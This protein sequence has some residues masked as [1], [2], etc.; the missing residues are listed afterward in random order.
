LSDG[1]AT[2]SATGG[3]APYSYSWNTNPPQNNATATNLAAGTYNVT[4][5]DNNGCSASTSVQITE[6][7]S[8]SC[9]DVYFPNAFT[10]NGDLVN[11]EFGALGNLAA[12]SNYLL[13][14]YNR[15]GELVFYT[16]NPYIRWNGFYK[17]KQVLGNYVWAVTYTYK[18]QYIREEKGSVTIIR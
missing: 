6:P 4:V 14:V 9:G 12:I 5:T 11:D 18:G 2:A 10:P 8:G 16:R 15:Y 17:G 3:N 7:A 13:L 1:T